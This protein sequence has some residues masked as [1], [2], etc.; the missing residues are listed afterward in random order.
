MDNQNQDL[1]LNRELSGSKRRSRLNL[2]IATLPNSGSFAG[3][4]GSLGLMP[5]I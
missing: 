2:G 3:Q 4:N 5:M 1:K